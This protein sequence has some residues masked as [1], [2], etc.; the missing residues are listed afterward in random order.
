[1]SEFGG[2]SREGFRRS[3]MFK[4]TTVR[5]GLDRLRGVV[6]TKSLLAELP[7]LAAKAAGSPDAEKRV[8]S[9]VADLEAA[10]SEESESAHLSKKSTLDL[11][12]LDG[13]VIEHV[14]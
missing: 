11:E 3:L 5:I 1:M 8:A 2:M 12:T 13:G 9:I 4:V 14:G 10:L 7:E 6:G